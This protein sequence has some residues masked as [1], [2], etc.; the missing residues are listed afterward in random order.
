MKALRQN[1]LNFLNRYYESG[2]SNIL[3]VYGHKNIDMT[4]LLTSF[5]E[6]K[7][8]CFYSARSASTKEQLYLWGKELGNDGAILDE[9]PDFNDIFDAIDKKSDTNSFVLMIRNFENIVRGSDQFMK[10]MVS[11]V[12]NNK[13]QILVLLI[14]NDIN[15]VE[16]N[17]VSELGDLAGSIAGFK[18][19]KPL[20]FKEMRAY[21]P[22][23]SYLDAVMTYSVLG[24]QT[25]LWDFFDEALSFK[26]NICK[27]FL[28]EGAFL[29][30]E[31]VRLTEQN[32]RETSVYHTLLAEMARGVNK[33]N[34]IYHATGFSRAKIS[35]YIKTLIH[36][37]FAYKAFSF[38]NA[39]RENVM[40]GVYKIADPLIDFYFKFIYPNESNL[41]LMPPE[42]F[43]DIFISAGMQT[44]VSEYF[45]NVCREYILNI[46]EQGQ[47]PFN[48]EDEGP[49]LGKEGNIDFVA[50]SDVGDT[51][52]G[53]S[54]WERMATH[55]DYVKLHSDARKA[56]LEGDVIYLFSTTGFDSWLKNAAVKSPESLKLIGIDELTNG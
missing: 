12:K 36:H 6:D 18:K 39:G 23:M 10:K 34:D 4:T 32:L 9:Y 50:Q 38:G 8:Y 15:W 49:W 52:F 55:A 31:A 28:C 37:D 11:F 42:Q 35:V 54:F 20:S 21:F 48:I 46:E 22:N 17:M 1:D 43:Y 16:N 19:I 13:K 29:R 44:Y 33:L 56:R 41:M 47:F 51:A 30:N 27:N 2:V 5:I 14:S 53:M 26:E 45:K 40:K 24:G 7:S 25:G 3:V